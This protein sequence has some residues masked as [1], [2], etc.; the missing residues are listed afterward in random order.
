MKGKGIFEVPVAKIEVI[1][2]L[3]PRIYTHTIEEKV[4]EY[5]EAMA[6]G[7][8]FPPITVWDKGGHYWLIDGMHRLLA[9]K[10]LGK[11][12]I[13]AE[14]VELE[15]E[16]EARLLAIEKNMLHGI[17]L[18]RE[19]KK[20]LAR[21]LYADGVEIEKLRK[22]FRVSERT[23]YN[24]VEGVKRR[25][26]DEELKRQA[27]E[28]RKQGLTQEEVARQLGV[29]QNTISMWEN[30][31][32]SQISQSAKIAGFDNAKNSQLLS[33][34]GTPTQEGFKALSEFIE[35]NE[36]E[37]R[38]KPFND[39]VKD[40]ALRD[41][42]KF[43]HESIKKDL[44]R[45]IDAPTYEKVKNYLITIYPYKELSLK[46][47]KI[48][49]DKAQALWEKMKKE[50]EEEIKLEREVLEQ[51][52]KVLADPE[53]VFHTWRTLREDLAR[54]GD[55]NHAFVYAYKEKIEEI[56]HR[57]ADTL[58]EIYKTIPEATPDALSED[59]LKEIK[60]KVKDT[61]KWGRTTKIR[62]EVEQRLKEK[63]LRPVDAV[64]EE[65][66]K[67]VEELVRQEE[68]EKLEKIA[69]EIERETPEETWEALKK[70]KEDYEKTFGKKAQE[71]KKTKEKEKK[72]KPLP[73]GIED[74]YRNALEELLL[75]MG[76][77]LTWPR[78]F[79]IAEEILKKVKEYSKTAV[80]GW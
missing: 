78:A 48:F 71:Q 70:D 37:L 7:Q 24:W 26:K 64:V 4:Q 8:E 51:A 67:R 77:A 10:R 60:E 12:T 15:N 5:Q 36:E 72:E 9:S 14:V 63:R 76:L 17:P 58:T 11:D 80:R 25:A 21:L 34:D 35:E 59:E 47:R 79:E 20:E 28:L 55:M 45:F 32:R 41:V 73:P 50:H 57:H 39:V 6:E 69:E 62:E 16:L 18:D 29:A 65:F 43:L 1:Q 75:K 27:L 46:A 52:K 2:G 22:L 42:L 33:P 38:Q 44:K 68:W 30:E 54:L 56:L 74:W 40:Q 61:D 31:T 23:V 49:F 53:Y 13:K 3:L 19:E 66:V